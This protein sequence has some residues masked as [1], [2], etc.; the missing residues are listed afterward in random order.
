[1]YGFTLCSEDR[2]GDI[3]RILFQGSPPW[4]D[5]KNK[6]VMDTFTYPPVKVSSPSEHKT[7]LCSTGVFRLD[8]Q[9][10]CNTFIHYY[11][12]PSIWHCSLGNTSALQGM[13]LT[14]SW[15]QSTT[16]GFYYTGEPKDCAV[17]LTTNILPTSIWWCGVVV[18]WSVGGLRHW[19][20]ALRGCDSISK[21]HQPVSLFTPK[22]HPPLYSGADSIINHHIIKII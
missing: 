12:K 3:S 17:N 10:R 9:G 16:L 22:Q 7:S 6:M 2:Q 13:S 1:M 14:A 8:T 11:A 21:A 5:I 4:H 15:E 19:T 20:V 18:D